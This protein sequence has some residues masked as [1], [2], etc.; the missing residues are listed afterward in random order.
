MLFRSNLPKGGGAISGM[1]EKFTVN[2]ITG[3]GTLTVPVGLSP[4][5]SGFTP[6]LT[7]SYDSGSGNGPRIIVAGS[8][9]LF[10][11]AW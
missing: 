5:R 9:S 2:P 1:G 8:Q 11:E 7:L 4:G 6:Q 3:T 10:D